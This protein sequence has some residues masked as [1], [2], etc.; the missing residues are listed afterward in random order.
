MKLFSLPFFARESVLNGMEPHSLFLLSFVSRKTRRM[1]KITIRKNGIGTVFDVVRVINRV[2][3]VLEGRENKTVVLFARESPV[4]FEYVPMTLLEFDDRKI[5]CFLT[6]HPTTGIPTIW[7][8]RLY[9][10]A[11]HLVIQRYICDLFKAPTHFQ[12]VTNPASMDILPEVREVENCEIEGGETRTRELDDMFKQLKVT[13]TAVIRPIIKG[14]FVSNSATM[15]I[16]NLVMI[17]ADFCGPEDLLY[18]FKGKN[19]I[20]LKVRLRSN[21]VNEF[22]KKW[23]ND[24][25]K[26]LETMIIQT[27][28][29]FAWPNRNGCL[30]EINWKNWDGK[31]RPQYYDYKLKMREFLQ[32]PDQDFF[33]CSNGV[34]I[35]RP[36]DKKRAT[37]IIT[38]EYFK[39][40]VWN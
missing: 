39:F 14:M 21:Y 4:F 19:A 9:P 34:D 25:L 2:N 38:N 5:Y 6:L 17:N 40:F 29:S 33:D 28:S 26:N 18:K 27:A 35:E 15:K 7:C 37:V 11:L 20:F 36:G 12:L 23:M 16:Q 1:I 22:L 10:I 31:S 24:K 3:L 8:Y 30:A 13:D 32:N